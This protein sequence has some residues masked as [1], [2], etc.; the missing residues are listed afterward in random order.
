MCCPCQLFQTVFT[1]FVD[2]RLGR[3]EGILGG[4][5]GVYCLPS[6]N[7]RDEG[8]GKVKLVYIG[9]SLRMGDDSIKSDCPVDLVD[10]HG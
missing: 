5:A 9:E 8:V 7:N 2:V 6:G 3:K 10:R 1:V 4:Q